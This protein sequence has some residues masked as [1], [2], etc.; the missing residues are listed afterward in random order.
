MYRSRSREIRSFLLHSL[1]RRST[2]SRL[3]SKRWV[4]L[5]SIRG[6]RLTILPTPQ[7]VLNVSLPGEKY[8]IIYDITLKDLTVTLQQA[9]QDYAALV[10]NNE[11]D[12]T[13]K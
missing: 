4:L 2:G 12:V 5:C 10:Q 13:F 9:S 1:D 8:Q 6:E 3:P 7:L 11:T